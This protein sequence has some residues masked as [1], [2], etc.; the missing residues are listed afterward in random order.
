LVWIIKLKTAKLLMMTFAY[1]VKAA[2]SMLASFACLSV[3]LIEGLPML[4][5]IGV[6]GKN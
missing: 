1:S 2:T 3:F 6:G 4:A 5:N